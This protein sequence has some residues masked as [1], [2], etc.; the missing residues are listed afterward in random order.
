MRLNKKNGLYLVGLTGVLVLLISLL[1]PAESTLG[2]WIK[3][4]YIHAGLAWVGVMVFVL[5]GIFGVLHLISNKTSFSKWSKSSQ[6][7]AVL[8]WVLNGLLAAFVTKM[9]WGKWL[10]LA[11]PRFKITIFIL[12]LAPLFYLLSL[13]AKDRKIVSILNVILSC[14]VIWLY[15]TAGSAIFHPTGPARSSPNLLIRLSFFVIVGLLSA[16]SLILIWI[17][18]ETD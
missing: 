10:F 9:I 8:I 16:A 13:W 1:S 14:V 11:E 12:V 18:K 3:V 7:I 6:K 15:S 4:L 2:D 5:A 17:M